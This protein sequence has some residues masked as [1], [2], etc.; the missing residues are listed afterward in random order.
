MKL[1]TINEAAPM[2]GKS[3]QQ[4]RRGVDSGRYPYVP[5]GSRKLVD[6]DELRE[7]IRAESARIGIKEAAELTG[8]PVNTIR[9]GVREGWIP[10]T[11]VGKEYEI[12]PGELLDTLE[13]MKKRETD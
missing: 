7:I 11:K 9:R 1:V 10:S 3:T 12:L 8:L 4:L 2:L 6:V 5:I 13:S